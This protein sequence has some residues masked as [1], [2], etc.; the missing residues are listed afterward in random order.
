MELMPDAMN[1]RCPSC[2]RKAHDRLLV[3]CPECRVPFVFD[4]QAY[5]GLTS[6]QLKL[7]AAQILGSWKFWA[8]LAVIVGAAAWATVKVADKIIDARATAYLNTLQETASNHLGAAAG[9]ISNQIAL[10]FRQPRI[11]AA[12]E[13]AARDQGVDFFSNG[14]KP[15]LEAFQGAMD[16]ANAQLKSQATRSSNALTQLEADIAAARRRIPDPVAAVPT[17]PPA[18]VPVGRPSPVIPD[19]PP[20]TTTPS[21]AN[22]VADG[23]V[24]LEKVNQTVVQAGSAYLLTIFFRKTANSAPRGMIE[25]DAATYKLSARI[26]SF[27]PMTTSP[28]EPSTLNETADIAQFHFTVTDRETPTLV[29]ELSAPTIV[30]LISDAFDNPITLNVNYKLSSPGSNR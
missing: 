29:M 28:F 10:E 17:R 8:S 14:V 6:E 15:T 16:I 5:P 24:H 11:K 30:Q 13:Q 25:V 2:G 20:D 7:V 27:T 9:Q 3:Q 26:L 18:A 12:I 4:D 21:D 23:A 1:R 19:A 22:A